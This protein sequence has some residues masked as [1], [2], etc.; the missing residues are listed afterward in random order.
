MPEQWRVEADPEWL[1]RHSSDNFQRIRRRLRGM[2]RLADA[3]SH[4]ELGPFAGAPRNPKLKIGGRAYA[5]VRYA[6]NRI[7]H[8][9]VRIDPDVCRR[10]DRPLVESATV[11]TIDENGYRTPVGTVRT[12]RWCQADS[13][14]FHSRMPS[15][16][17]ARRVARRIVL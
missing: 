13:W 11:T 9:V 8:T 14:M 12:C 16:A 1:A 10:C 7:S 5:V 2:S 3:I 6:A 17:R 4:A 15:V